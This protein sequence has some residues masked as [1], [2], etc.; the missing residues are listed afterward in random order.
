M[1]AD[2]KPTRIVILGGGFGGV[3]A[4]MTLEKGLRRRDD[5]EIVLV[6][7]ENYFVFQPMLAEVLS[8]QM[9]ILEPV[10]P[11]RRL[12]P[13][14]HLYFRDISSV[15][16]EKKLVTLA[17]GYRPR[18]LVLEYDHL[19]IALGDVTDFRFDPG[20][21]AHAL[22]F[23][24]LSDT[25]RLRDH[26]LR[27]LGEAEIEDDDELRQELLTFVIA[28][29]GYSGVEVAASLNDFVREVGPKTFGLEPEDI[30][31]ILIHSKERLLQR[32]LHSSLGE[33]AQRILRRRG[34]ELMLEHRLR[35]ATETHA[36]LDDGSRICTRTLV[37]T[38]PSS[39]NPLVESIALRQKKGK[40][41][42]DR[43]MRVEGSTSE[44]ALGDCAL[45]PHPS[46]EGDCPKTAQFAVR[47]ATTC[48]HN[49]LAAIDGRPAK[50][51]NFTGLG[52]LGVLGHRTAVAQLPGGLKLSGLL[53]WLA[54]R[55][56][57]WWK[58]P[59]IDR[60]VRIALSWLL[61]LV[62]P[63]ELVQSKFDPPQAMVHAHFEPGEYV[64]REGDV[65]D[66]LYII[67]QGKA[68]I[69]KPGSFVSEPEVMAEVG[70]G[71]IFGEMALLDGNRRGATVRCLEPLDVFTMAKNEFSHL[72][73]FLP[74]LRRNVEQI[75]KQRQS[76][77]PE[78]VP[79]DD[80][81]S[82]S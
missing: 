44:W 23:K 45:I 62:V 50:T 21:R 70:P 11:I 58:L 53:A 61:D 67:I 15:D 64:I 10:I 28:G 66:R 29:G 56:I 35:S 31:V 49:I 3:Y 68:E 74:D 80:A 38:V 77:T 32:E 54:W 48:A 19:V 27:V 13:R 76:T 55:T 12:C 17:P 43:T 72:V 24:N 36:I 8:G 22:P 46:G 7:R 37:S 9:G 75:A 20:L 79:S 34:V 81:C 42:A 63:P 2:T 14:T 18:P 26:V 41:I 69:L 16:V 25:L 5:I 60:K 57:Y 65:G 82:T 4:A 52:S 78:P 33:Y 1:D 6:N 73:N 40:I 47:Q 59:G 30:R 51:F 39:P 71:E